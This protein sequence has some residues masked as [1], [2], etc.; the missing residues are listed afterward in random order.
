MA[1]SLLTSGFVA[2]ALSIASAPAV[3]GD[4]F[5]VSRSDL[6]VTEGTIE[7]A[8]NDRMSVDVPKMRAYATR[9][10][11]QSI[12]LR[13]RYAGPTRKESAL[14][15]GQMRRQVGLKLRA[16]DSCNLVYAMW[17]ID[18]EP[19]LVVSLKRNPSEP[20]ARNVAITV[21]STSSLESHCLF[22]DYSP[23]SPTP[24]G[25]N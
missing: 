20:P 4:W 8:G 25:L 1:K 24:C 17:R 15:S 21:T 16:Q 7:N 23:A 2:V 14:G 6:C 13:F 10:S 11:E 19:K 18:P 9:A 3:A 5:T 22:R 12:G